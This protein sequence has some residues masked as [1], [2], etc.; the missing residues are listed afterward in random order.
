MH[1]SPGTSCQYVYVRTLPICIIAFNQRWRV[2]RTAREVKLAG[3]VLGRQSN[4]LHVRPTE[5]KCGSLLM[6]I[7]TN[8]L[9]Y[10]DNLM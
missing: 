3:P 7:L 5:T 2:G 9:Q 4:N 8:V 1:D 6:H 10:S